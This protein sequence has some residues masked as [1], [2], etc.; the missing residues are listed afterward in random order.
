MMQNG[1]TTGKYRNITPLIKR[2]MLFTFSFEL[3]GAVLL[4]IFLPIRSLGERAFA[5]IFHSVSAFCNA[6]FSTFSN[7]LESCATSI[8]VNLIFITLIVSGGIGFLV[9]NEIGHIIRKRIPFSRLSLHSKLVI[10]T[11]ALLLIVGTVLIFI[12]ENHGGGPISRLLNAFFQA[13]TTRTAGFNTVDLS[14]YARQTLFLICLLMFIGASPG[15]TGGGIKTT[16]AA[17]IFAYI[18]S[19]IFGKKKTELF[20]RSL[21]VKTVE[22]AFLVTIVSTVLIAVSVF[23]LLIFEPQIPLQHLVF[24]V[25]SAFGTVGLSLGITSAL[26]VAAK[27][28][29]MVTMFIGR[30]GPST[31][32]L[33]ISRAESKAII[34]YPEED[35]M[36]G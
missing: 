31:L 25:F 29:I 28:V 27:I 35:I 1:F 21:P 2:I 10:N 11:T 3:L 13:V 8:P 24:E 12:F 6:G 5:S 30:I 26:G 19:Y 20:Y 32:L 17:S 4:F 36:I 23:L 9:L 34:T 18:K 15:S 22:K 33:A 16:S 14:L 7:S